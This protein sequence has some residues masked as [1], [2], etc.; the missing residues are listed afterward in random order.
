MRGRRVTSQS[1]QVILRPPCCRVGS[2]CLA[3][4]FA[5]DGLSVLRGH[6]VGVHGLLTSQDSDEESEDVCGCG[7]VAIVAAVCFVYLEVHGTY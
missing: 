3:R 2:K 6:C 7:F 4:S 1:S 5:A